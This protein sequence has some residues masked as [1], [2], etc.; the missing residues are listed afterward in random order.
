MGNFKRVCVP[1]DTCIPREAHCHRCAS[2]SECDMCRDGFYLHDGRCVASCP[3]GYSPQGTV[4]PTVHTVFPTV[5]AVFPT[6]HAVFP[7]VHAVFPTLNTALFISHTAPHTTCCDSHS[8]WYVSH[9]TRAQLFPVHIL[10][11]FLLLLCLYC[12][13]GAWNPV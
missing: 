10:C 2:T 12:S 11:C 8:A 13:G 6:V 3:M 1:V 4:F 5:L 7:T 9:A